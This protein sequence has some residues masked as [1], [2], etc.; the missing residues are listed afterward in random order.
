MRVLVTAGPTREALDP[1]RFLSNRSSG[2]MG[3]AIAE[4]ALESGHE[5]TL[6]SGPVALSP[7]AGA[8]VIR[9]T[10]ADELFDAVHAHVAACDLLV[11][12]AAVC[13]YKPLSVSAGKLPKQTATFTLELTPTRDVLASLAP[14]E[15]SFY[16]VGFAAETQNLEGN[17][18]A[19]LARKHC[20][21]IIANDVSA[22]D[23]GM[24]SDENAATIF[25]ANG[26]R[27]VFARAEKKLLAREM[28]K[29]IFTIAQKSLTKK[30]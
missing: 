15:R 27:A 28:M 20:D 5:V 3:Y 7:P 23:V 8:E 22:E 30:T 14:N 16:V 6:I 18:L 21:A 2:K 1:V 19:K 13:D 29:K 17:A 10:T 25:F 9:I 24:E 4:A 26:E 12:C 11:M